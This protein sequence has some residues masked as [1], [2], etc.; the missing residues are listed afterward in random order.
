M[1][2]NPCIINISKKKNKKKKNSKKGS[3]DMIVPSGGKASKIAL[4]GTVQLNGE[5]VVRVKE[6]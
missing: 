2:C 1:A 5:I 3:E 4:N 6:V